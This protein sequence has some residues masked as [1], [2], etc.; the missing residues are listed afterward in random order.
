MRKQVVELVKSTYKGF[1][2]MHFSEKLKKKEGLGLSRQSVQR[3]MPRLLFRDQ[4]PDC[5]QFES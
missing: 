5:A 1:N 2:D 3:P 4:L